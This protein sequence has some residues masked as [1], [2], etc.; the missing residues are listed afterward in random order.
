[1]QFA[2]RLRATIWKK[3]CDPRCC[4]PPSRTL[5]APSMLV[6]EGVDRRSL[7]DSFWRCIAGD[8]APRWAPAKRNRVGMWFLFSF[9]RGL[10][11][12][13][14]TVRQDCVGSKTT[15]HSMKL[16]LKGM[17]LLQQKHG[18]VCTRIIWR[19]AYF[20]YSGIL[21][22]G[23]EVTGRILQLWGIQTTLR[24][25]VVLGNMMP[26][27]PCLESESGILLQQKTTFER[28]MRRYFSNS[29]EIVSVVCVRRSSR[30]CASSAFF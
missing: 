11:G 26:S 16:L 23:I 3:K 21:Q 6:F 22:C 18:R 15:S 24:L 10:T 12:P 2:H 17:F 30:S 20:K 1:M 4:I 5:L 28:Q 7:F 27:F 13:H 8:F 29:V 9:F 19:G 25:I 14:L